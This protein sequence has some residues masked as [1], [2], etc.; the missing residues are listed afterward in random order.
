MS[1]Q[2]TT[3]FSAQ[4]VALN[5]QAPL[6]PQPAAQTLAALYDAL[7]HGNLPLLGY[8]AHDEG[9]AHALYS[10]VFAHFRYSEALG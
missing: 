5:G 2:E 10:V 4:A 9:N 7:K 3:S 6:T 8:E 1:R